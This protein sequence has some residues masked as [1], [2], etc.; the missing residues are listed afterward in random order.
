MITGERKV[1]PKVGAKGE[2]KAPAQRRH[3]LQP[4]QAAAISKQ[5]AAPSAFSKEIPHTFKD[6][7]AMMA[8]VLQGGEFL[9]F[10]NKGKPQIVYIDAN[11]E[12]VF[13]GQQAHPSTREGH[14]SVYVR[15]RWQPGY[16]P[17]ALVVDTG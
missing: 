15:P 4:R 10:Q 14:K 3:T 12:K 6:N 1:E 2:S 13:W 17:R 8:F 16:K 11:Q 9:Q 7:D 5:F